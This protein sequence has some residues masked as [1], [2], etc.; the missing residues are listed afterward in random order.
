MFHA[1]IRWECKLL[2]FKRLA[3]ASSFN[4]QI[5]KTRTKGILWMNMPGISLF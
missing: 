4:F 2:D 3:D 5:I 1:I